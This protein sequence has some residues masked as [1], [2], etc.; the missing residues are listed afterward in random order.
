MARPA[1][2]PALEAFLATSG[3]VAFISSTDAAVSPMQNIA[4]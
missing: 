4:L 3:T 1:D 2:W